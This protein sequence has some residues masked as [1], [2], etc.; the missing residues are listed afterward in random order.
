MSFRAE[1][2]AQDSVSQRQIEEFAKKNILDYLAHLNHALGTT[3]FVAGSCFS[4]A[5]C[6]L[7]VILGWC[8]WLD[9]SIGDFSNVDRYFKD[10]NERPGTQ[11]ALSL[12]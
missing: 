5:D 1:D 9:I 11:L 4:I 3:K 7:V 10:A 2:M 8:D 12:Q 6:Y